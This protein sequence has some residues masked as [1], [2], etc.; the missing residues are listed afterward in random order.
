MFGDNN[1]ITKI[2]KYFIFIVELVIIITYIIF[3]YK[4]QFPD[5]Q[6]SEDNEDEIT[7]LRQ[8]SL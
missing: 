3:V 8:L 4:S 1:L 6:E 7:F 2:I 5:L